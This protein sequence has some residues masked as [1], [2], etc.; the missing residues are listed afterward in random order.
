MA[1]VAFWLTLGAATA[2]GM[3]AGASL[4]QCIKQLPAR[5]R[6]GVKVYA[7]YSQ[8]ADLGNGIVF[9]GALGIGSALLAV[10]AAVAIHLTAL[11]VTA[12]LAADLG[13]A[14]AVLH[15]LITTRAAPI[16]FLQLQAAETPEVLAGVFDRFSRWQ[17]LRAAVQVVNFGILLWAVVE[18]ASVR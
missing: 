17:A 11:S 13:A 8:A 7:A 10:A 9:Y 1:Q 2:A 18:V 4:D 12:T 6:I 3:L 15:Y 5:H 16:L 14:F